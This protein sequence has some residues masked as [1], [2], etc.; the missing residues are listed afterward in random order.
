MSYKL[1]L[2]LYKKVSEKSSENT[3][4]LYVKTRF[5]SDCKKRTRAGT[6]IER[7]IPVGFFFAL[8]REGCGLTSGEALLFDL[9]LKGAV[10]A[11]WQDYWFLLSGY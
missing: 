7:I 9:K 6:I 11:R 4:F 1:L 8:S 10:Q 3:V 5:L 2:K